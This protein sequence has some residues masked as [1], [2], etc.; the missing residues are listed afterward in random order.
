[1]ENDDLTRQLIELFRAASEAH[2]QAFLEAG[3]EDPEWPLWYADHLLTDLAEALNATFTK[4][5]LVYLLVWASKEQ[6]LD[7]PGADWAV[8]YARFFEQR[9]A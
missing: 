9:Y 3:G 2:H 6:A 5:E 4:S 1:M 8:Y 7:A